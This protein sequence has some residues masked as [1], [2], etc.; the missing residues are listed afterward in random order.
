MKRTKDDAQVS[1]W[2]DWLDGW[3][4]FLSLGEWKQVWGENE[5]LDFRQIKYE[6]S[7]S[8]KGRY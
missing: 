5:E 2:S 7:E 6:R 8:S 1:G 4:C 3:C